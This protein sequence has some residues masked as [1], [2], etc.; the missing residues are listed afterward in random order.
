MSKMAGL[1]IQ[2][3]VGL[4]GANKLKYKIILTVFL[5]GQETQSR[6]FSKGAATEEKH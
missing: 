6:N 2:Q 3:A 4:L 1:A 5:L